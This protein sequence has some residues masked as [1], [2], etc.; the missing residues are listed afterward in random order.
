MVIKGMFYGVLIG[1]VV[2]IFVWVLLCLIFDICIYSNGVLMVMIFVII[3]IVGMGLLFG[4]FV[5]SDYG[6]YVWLLCCMGVFVE[7]VECFGQGIKNG[8]ILVIVCDFN[9]QC[10]DEVLS[11]MCC[12]GVVCF[13]DVFGGGRFQSECVGQNGY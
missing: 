1:I 11:I 8:L 9:G 7:Q 6:D 12:S 10:V 3:G 5:G 13:E 2:M 4:V